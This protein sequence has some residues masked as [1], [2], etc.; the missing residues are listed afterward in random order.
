MEISETMVSLHRC[1]CVC[2]WG[3]LVRRGG[4][5]GERLG[6]LK[7][8][9]FKLFRTLQEVEVCGGIPSNS[10]KE[11]DS[12]SPE[13]CASKLQVILHSKYYELSI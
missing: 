10:F 5:N 13:K 3:L 9:P 11:L 6:T 12:T 8:F 1:V 4:G 7:I 2:V